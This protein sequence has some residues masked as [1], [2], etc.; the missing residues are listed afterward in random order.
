M[1]VGIR[2]TTNVAPSIGKSWHHF[3]DKWR[4]LCRYSSLADSDQEVYSFFTSVVKICVVERLVN[5]I[6]N[7]NPYIVFQ[8][9]VNITWKLHNINKKKH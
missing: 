9:H 4:S 2:H 1:A 3:A 7:P 6:I 5:P 8:L